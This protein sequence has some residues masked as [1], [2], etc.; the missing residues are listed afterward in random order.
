MSQYAKV[1]LS[2]VIVLIGANAL[3]FFLMVIAEVFPPPNFD[4]RIKS[5]FIANQLVASDW[6]GLDAHRGFDQYNDCM[7]LQMIADRQ[8]DI[9]PRSVVP[10]VFV[11]TDE[12]SD[13][14]DTLRQLVTRPGVKIDLYQD[15][16]GRYWHGYTAV[17]TAL[18]WMLD[19]NEVRYLLKT[20]V[21][22]SIGLFLFVG[23]KATR[24][25]FVFCTS[26]SFCAAA[27]WALPYFGQGLSYAPAEAAIFLGLSLLILGRLWFWEQ[28]VRL[29]ASMT[30]FGS[31]IVFL[32]FLTGQLPTA[33]AFLVVITFLISLEPEREYGVRKSWLLAALSLTSFTVG[34]AGTVVAKQVLVLIVSG[35]EVLQPFFANLDLYTG[36]SEEASNRSLTAPILQ[37][38]RSADILVYGSKTGAKV[39]LISAI[40]SWI[41]AAAIAFWLRNKL[42]LHL[43]LIHCVGA[44]S[45]PAWV[46]LLPTHTVIHASFMTRILIIPI[47]LG[48]SALAMQA[49]LAHKNSRSIF[50]PNGI[51]GEARDVLP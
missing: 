29:L 16:Y 5:Q 1:G 23:W 15:D 37:L 21:F 33:A 32:E 26:I 7:V 41:M 48:F 14:C 10:K 35:T 19:L 2:V 6:P 22:V 43:L 11:T 46:F 13:V 50:G 25:L 28:P 45:L 39:L 24:T 34:A 44:A 12:Y 4:Q 36:G 18:L 51:L 30:L 8:G 47:S 38:A 31:L 49:I 9:L 42:S 17:S 27:F 40:I 20:A 3:F